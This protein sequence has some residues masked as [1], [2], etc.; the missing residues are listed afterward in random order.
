M[1]DG[2]RANIALFVNSIQNDYSTLMCQGAAVAAEELDVNL[3]IVP[4]REINATWDNIAI[5]R[6][7]NQSSVLYTFINSHNVDVLIVSMGTVGFFL[8]DVQR[9]EFLDQYK[10]L[11]ILVLESEVEGYPSLLFDMSGLRDEIEH[12]IKHHGKRK[13]AFLS[14]P[15]GNSVAEERLALFRQIVKENDIDLDESYIGYGDFTDY[16]DEMVESMFD[17]FSDGMPEALICANDTMVKSVKNVCQKRGIRLGSDLL[18]AGYDDAAFASVMVPS[19]TT[20]KSNIMSMGYQ[21]V[22]S[23]AEY[24]RT[25]EYR[26]TSVKTSLVLRQSCGC[27]PEAVREKETED[28][29]LSCDRDELIQKIIDYTLKKSSMDVIPRAQIESISTFISAVY[30]KIITD[31]HVSSREVGNLVS[32]LLQ[33][34]NLD[35]LTF[36]SINAVMYAMKKLA[37]EKSDSDGQRERIYMTFERVFRYISLQFAENSHETEERMKT[38]R[39]VFSRI[40]DDMMAYGSEENEAF[41]HLMNDISMLHVKS[42]YIYLYHKSILSAANRPENQNNW[43]R[44]DNIYLKAIYD[45]EKFVFP[46]AGDQRM[47]F[48]SFFSHRYMPYGQRKTVILQALYFNNEQY[49]IMMIECKLGLISEINNIS[50]QICTAIKLS[51]FMNQLEGAL[52]DVRKANVQ[53]SAESVTDQLTGI[54]NRR[55]FISRSE[56]LLFDRKGTDRCGAVLYADLDCLKTINDTFGHREGDFAIRKASEILVNSLRS[57]DVVGRVGGDEFVAFIMDTDHDKLMSVCERIKKSAAEFNS[58][59]DK[60]YNIGISIGLY[61]FNTADGESI[62]QLMSGADRDLYNKKKLKN[63]S[64][65]KNPPEKGNSAD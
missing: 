39:F 24:F 53:L 3:M 37:L 59:S 44:P 45:N 47:S 52:E 57:T 62:D 43:K 64:V 29:T 34:D 56:K 9:K 16:C 10:D 6:F 42:C 13:I 65:L 58:N 20:V 30:E 41:R 38:D 12:I 55:G 35:F 2:K 32:E 14:G 22:E 51:Q 63:R 19:L 18:V 60:P 4:G 17:G 36:D 25:G 40:A 49:G 27:V 61:C 5:N 46:Q 21:A 54:Y 48:E 26:K 31:T 8:D 15:K 7:E 33:G 23:A 11:K 28:I 50:K 1:R